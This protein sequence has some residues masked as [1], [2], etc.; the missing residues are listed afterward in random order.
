MKI[1]L[2]LGCSAAF[3]VPYFSLQRLRPIE[4]RVLPFFWLDHVLS[5]SSPWVVVYQSA[6]LPIFGVPFLLTTRAEIAAWLRGFFVICLPAFITFYIEPVLAPAPRALSDNFLLS[7]VQLYDGQINCFPSLHAAL[8]TYAAALGLQL[9]RQH[10]NSNTV[11]ALL[12]GGLIIATAAILLSTVATKQHYAVDLIAGVLLGLVGF[13]V[14][15][16]SLTQGNANHESN[17]PY[18]DLFRSR[19]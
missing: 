1:A 8:S 4:G 18:S 6:Y 13:R 12:K 17:P 3:C 14:F 11:R 19:G 7:F 16:A 9:N 5:I 15:D 10:R 2:A